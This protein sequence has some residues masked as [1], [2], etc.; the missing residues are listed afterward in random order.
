VTARVEQ[1]PATAHVHG[2]A[3]TV[4][5]TCAVITC[6]H[7]GCGALYVHDG[8]AT[9]AARERGWTSV[10]ERDGCQAH[11]VACDDAAPDAARERGR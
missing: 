10:H 4:D 5:A 3:L 1:H 9:I 2:L 8:E 7:D 11:P 6:D